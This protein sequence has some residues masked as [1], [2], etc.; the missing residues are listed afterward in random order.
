MRDSK[1]QVSRCVGCVKSS[2]L[3]T[4]LNKCSAAAEMGDRLATLDVGRKVGAAVPRFS[5]DRRRSEAEAT[6]MDRAAPP[7]GGSGIPI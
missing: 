3:G 2:V 1:V 5:G 6:A 4:D 7:L